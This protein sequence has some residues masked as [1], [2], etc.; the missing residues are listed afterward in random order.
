MNVS[1]EAELLRSA[2]S[3]LAIIQRGKPP[4]E[5]SR[6]FI[7]GVFMIIAHDLRPKKKF[8]WC[9]VGL[10]PKLGVY[11]IN[12]FHGVKVPNKKVPLNR[13][14]KAFQNTTSNEQYQTF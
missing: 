14:I 7:P 11:F 3:P 6:V 2:Q 10:H 13:E 1:F 9:Y 8:S 5:A 4:V 12:Q